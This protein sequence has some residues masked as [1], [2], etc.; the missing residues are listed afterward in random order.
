MGVTYKQIEEVIETGETE[1]TAKK[2]I[3]DRFEKSKHKRRVAPTYT[4]RRK[5]YLLEM[6][7]EVKNKNG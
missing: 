1:E 2:I 5:N 7:E 3:I 6:E 4:F